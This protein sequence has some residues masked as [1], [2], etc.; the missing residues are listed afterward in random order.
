MP[1]P[2]PPPMSPAPRLAPPSVLR[3]A[4]APSMLLWCAAAWLVALLRHGCARLGV[5]GWPPCLPAVA[6]AAVAGA[7]LLGPCAHWRC[8]AVGLGGAGGVVAE[9][10][11]HSSRLPLPLQPRVGALGDVLELAA[12][13]VGHMSPLVAVWS[14]RCSLLR[15]PSLSRRRLAVC[16][17][18]LG[19]RLRAAAWLV[20]SGL[21]LARRCLALAACLVVGLLP[22][23]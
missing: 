18:L 5:V 21:G 10:S 16:A 6:S 8:L 3:L 2:W 13:P 4:F 23:T 19:L 17:L 11:F 14:G 1:P 12:W 15:S 22:L 9:L 20:G 7:V